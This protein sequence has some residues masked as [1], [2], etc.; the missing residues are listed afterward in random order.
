[1]KV[2]LSDSAKLLKTFIII[3]GKVYTGTHQMHANLYDAIVKNGGAD[4]SIPYYYYPRG[5]LYDEN[6]KIVIVGPEEFAE[7]QQYKIAAAFKVQ[8]EPY[9][10]GDSPHYSE[11][12]VK[13]FSHYETRI[14]NENLIQKAVS[15]F[16]SQ[17]NKFWAKESDFYEY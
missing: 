16:K 13:E 9:I 7:A 2:K 14:P 3:N 10:Y 4:E 12:Q 11:H 6:D 8:K 1:M 15:F 17:L 5:A